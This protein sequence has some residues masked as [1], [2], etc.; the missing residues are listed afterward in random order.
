[1]STEPIAAAAQAQAYATPAPIT[2]ADAPT[3]VPGPS[4][5]AGRDN[6]W[7]RDGTNI[8]VEQ[9]MTPPSLDAADENDKALQLNSD[10]PCDEVG[11]S[12]VDQAM[13][14]RLAKA[15]IRREID[16]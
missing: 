9:P 2:I 14:F 7:I 4:R 6:S 1:M 5:V 11:L 12:L 3:D 15:H 10:A 16:F 8:V 13:C